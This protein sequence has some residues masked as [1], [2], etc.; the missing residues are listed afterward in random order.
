MPDTGLSLADFLAVWVFVLVNLPAP[1]P[2][3][4]NTISVAMGSGRRAGLGA[5][6]GVGLGIGLWSVS[7]FLGMA[8]LFGAVPQARQV[9]TLVAAGLLLWFAARAFRA[10][11][12]GW[13]WRRQSGI[14]QPE[15]GTTWRRSFTR[16]VAISVT[17]PKALTTWLAIT[18]LFPVARASATDIALLTLG[19]MVSAL[20]VHSTYALAFST[21]PAA[22]AYLRAAPAINAGIG[23]F[24]TLFAMSL[25]LP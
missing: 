6:L 22:R 3:V 9:M 24:F 2:N 23:L 20:A 25:I 7:A 13:R 11:W 12:Q 16:A 17:N 18:A 14:P 8:A 15:T 5:A 21:P 4:M 10:A 19:V 1:G